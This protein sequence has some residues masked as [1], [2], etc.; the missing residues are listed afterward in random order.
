MNLADP[1]PSKLTALRRSQRVC[2]SV[3]IQVVRS[4]PGKPQTTEETRTLVVSAHGA[5]FVLQ[6]AVRAGELLILKHQKTQE[7]LVCRVVNFTPDQSGTFE[8]GV[9]FE[10]PAPKFWRIAFPPSDW[11]PRSP[12]AKAPTAKPLGGRPLA[13]IAGA[14]PGDSEKSQPVAS[15]RLF[16]KNL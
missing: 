15:N 4:E 6:M 9:E 3:P 14:M 16:D 7:Q 5:L 1:Q 13:K 11:S 2:L 8:V 10:H 12:D